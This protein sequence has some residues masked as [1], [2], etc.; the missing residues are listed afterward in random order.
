MSKNAPKIILVAV[1]L[2]VAGALIF[3]NMS[4]GSSS[5]AGDEGLIG[6]TTEEVDAYNENL[7]EEDAPSLDGLKKSNF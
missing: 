5:G 6:Q 3:Y 2:S 7:A 1:C 4:S